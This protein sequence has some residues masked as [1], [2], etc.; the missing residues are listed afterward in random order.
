MPYLVGLGLIALHGLWHLAKVLAYIFVGY[1]IYDNVAP[2]SSQVTFVILYGLVGWGLFRKLLF[3]ESEEEKP[4][5]KPN[6]HPDAWKGSD[7]ELRENMKNLLE[8]ERARMIWE[9]KRRR[10]DDF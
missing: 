6:L 8:K 4:A 9:E 10:G 7:E 5:R 3:D 1:M 2:G